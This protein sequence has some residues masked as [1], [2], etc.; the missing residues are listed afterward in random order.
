MKQ[1][2]K[3]V[4]S[5]ICFIIV[6]PFYIFYKLES[7]IIRTEQPFCGM[8]QLFSLIPGLI[9]EYMRREFY[10]LSL[11]KCSDDCCICFGTIFSHPTAEVWKGVYIGAYCTIGMVSIGENVL[12]G[13]NVDIMSGRRQHSF[14]RLDLPIKEQDGKFKRIHIGA[15]TWVGNGAI[16]MANVGAKCIIGAGSVVNQDIEDFSIAAGNPA[17]IVKKREV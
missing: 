1:C 2:I 7:S 4:A 10:K 17:G 12:L 6:V 9:G 5:I 3:R 15:D 14:E 8:S 11:Q 13:S 16:I